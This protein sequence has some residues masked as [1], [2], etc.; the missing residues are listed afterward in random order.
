MPLGEGDF[1]LMDYTLKVKETGQVIDTTSE[2]VAKQHGIY[3][4]EKTYEPMLVVIGAGWVLRSLEEHLKE[5]DVGQEKTIELPP[6]EAYGPRDPRKV[7][8]MPARRISQMGV[9]PRVGQRVEIDG[10]VGIIRA[11]GSGRVQVDF[12]HPLAGKTL[13]YEV[14]IR[15]KIEDPVRKVRALIHRRLPLVP[16]DKFGV[17]LG[18]REAV[19]KVP[20]EALFIEGIQAVKRGIAFDV[21][22]FLEGIEVV[23]FVEEFR[24]T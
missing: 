11:V 15:D 21:M 23:R 7:V 14:A 10:R 2:E 12:N 1:I 6:E 9:R 5:M 24:K 3:R 19:I 18:K 16:A 22:K 8:M 20:E 4:P 17:E 13:V